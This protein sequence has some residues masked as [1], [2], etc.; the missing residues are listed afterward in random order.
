[1]NSSNLSSLA[2]ILWSGMLIIAGSIWVLS[3]QVRKLADVLEDRENQGAAVVRP[4][5]PDRDSV[6]VSVNIPRVRRRSTAAL[7]RRVERGPAERMCG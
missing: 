3:S 5:V 4:V 2:F 7:A 1:M 6:A